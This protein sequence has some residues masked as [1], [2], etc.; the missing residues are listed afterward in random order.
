MCTCVH[1]HVTVNG[2]HISAVHGGILQ[3]I[4]WFEK[5]VLILSYCTGTYSPFFAFF[6]DFSY[7]IKRDIIL[8]RYLEQK[9][10]MIGEARRL[11]SLS[12]TF[13]FT[14]RSNSNKK[15]ANEDNYYAL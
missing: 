14:E 6:E 5:G 4:C 10:A 8:V 1:T 13:Y 12:F 11:L 15:P 9:K 3:Q 2:I 7:F